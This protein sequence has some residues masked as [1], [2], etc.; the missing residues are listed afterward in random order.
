[1]GRGR[2]IDHAAVLAIFDGGERNVA[3]IARRI[4]CRS[5]AVT[6]ILLRNG[7][8][9][10]SQSE[11]NR[12]TLINMSAEVRAQAAATYRAKTMLRRY[13]AMPE[14]ARAKFRALLDEE[15]T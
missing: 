2:S 15:P 14:L 13:R 6:Y 12:E 10:R 9:P 1:M 7:R 5:P 3:E 8:A 11:A 4:G